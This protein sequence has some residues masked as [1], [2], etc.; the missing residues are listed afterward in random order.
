MIASIL[1]DLELLLNS[2]L[3]SKFLGTAMKTNLK[4]FC[5]TV[6][7]VAFVAITAESNGNSALEYFPASMSTVSSSAL[8]AAAS[9]APTAK[10]DNSG[11][12][13]AGNSDSNNAVLTLA[14]KSSG[15]SSLNHAASLNSKNFS[16]S[17]FKEIEEEEEQDDYW[18]ALMGSFEQNPESATWFNSW[19]MNHGSYSYD[20]ETGQFTLSYRGTGMGNDSSSLP[21]DY[22][23]NNFSFSGSSNGSDNFLIISNNPNNYPSPS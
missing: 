16:V 18:N 19:V 22:S 2:Y 11:S 20:P 9:T 3:S 8:F 23:Y 4:S 10:L 6:S 12:K 1:I 5:L 13:K 21:F 15:D 17:G 14:S 7:A